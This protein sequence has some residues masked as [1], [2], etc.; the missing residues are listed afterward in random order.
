[1]SVSNFKFIFQMTVSISID[2]ERLFD[3]F[4]NYL[5]TSYA[6]FRLTD[7]EIDRLREW[8]ND[9][10]KLFENVAF[11]NCFE[12]WVWQYMK[13]DPNHK[14]EFIDKEDGTKHKMGWSHVCNGTSTMAKEFPRH[15]NDWICENDDFT[16]A[17]VWFQ[18]CLLG[19]VVYG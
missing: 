10:P 5:P 12:T 16:T 4:C 1:V 18:C 17:D 19:D 6:D 9:N 14:V 8:K 2:D 11:A 15:F 7:D 3:L 13:A